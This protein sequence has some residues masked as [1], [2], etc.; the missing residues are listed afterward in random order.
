[1]Q[2]LGCVV[3]PALLQDWRKWLVANPAPYWLT[4]ELADE[5]S[6]ELSSELSGKLSNVGQLILTRSEFG[7]LRPLDPSTAPAGLGRWS[8]HWHDSY[9]SWAMALEAS[10]VVFL[11]APELQLLPSELRQTL[12]QAQSQLNNGQVYDWGQFGPLI[13]DFL[14]P[15]ATPWCI[16]TAKG[17]QI[18][19]DTSLWQ[20]LPA[21]NQ[22]AWLEKYLTGLHCRYWSLSTIERKRLGASVSAVAGRFGEFGNCFATVLAGLASNSQQAKSIA[23]IFV[24]QS[25]FLRRLSELGFV[26]TGPLDAIEAGKLA[27]LSDAVLVWRNN[28]G[29][30][31]AAYLV[32]DGFVLNK[33]SQCW[34]SP[35]QIVLLHEL[36][37]Y[38]QED[39][40]ELLLYRRD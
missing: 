30:Q 5:L 18:V 12:L 29:P 11:S 4:G 25:L 20:L 15:Q 38:W 26:E 8:P 24:P 13:P 2:V 27:T 33:N 1:M 31:H 17:R 7:Q 34:Y 9:Q 6:S 37:A 39:G 32:H 23:S 28:H 3:S 36:L 19:L 16:E 14:L 10:H 21:S 40:F 35:R 22:K